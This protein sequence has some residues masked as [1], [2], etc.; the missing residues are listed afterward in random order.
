MLSVL[1]SRIPAP[2]R[3]EFSS[4][5]ALYG[6]SL[7]IT[8]Y[9]VTW[10]ILKDY[11]IN[12]RINLLHFVSS[13]YEVLMI[14]LWKLLQ[15]LSLRFICFLQEFIPRFMYVS[16]YLV[17]ILMTF[18]L[19]FVLY[20]VICLEWPQGIRFGYFY[21]SLPTHYPIMTIFCSPKH[22][23]FC[24]SHKLRT[25]WKWMWGSLSLFLCVYLK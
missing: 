10:N 2:L 21:S 13:L 4:W 24:F 18:I 7:Y 1:Y 23:L 20:S 14:D 12:E 3:Q 11:W 19:V 6:L 17:S 25:F 8:W 22:L 16:L 5:S 9:I 15:F